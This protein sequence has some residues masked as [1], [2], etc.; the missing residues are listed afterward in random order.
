MKAYSFITS[1]MGK[2]I[3]TLCCL[4]LIW[5]N[6]HTQSSGDQLFASDKPLE[7]G[8]HIA[9]RDVADTKKD[10]VYIRRK[11]NFTMEDGQR[12]SIDVS[13]KSRGNF[14]L[15]E[16]HFPPLWLKFEK[17][18]A[19]GTVFQGN[20]KLKLV[21]PCRSDAIGNQLIV[22][23][24]LCYKIYEQIS[25]FVFRTRLVNVDFTE[26]RGKKEKHFQLKGILIE[27]VEKL[28]DRLGAKT[29]EEAKVHS[30]A[31]EDTNALRFAFFQ[32]MIANTDLSRTYQHNT[33][34]IQAKDG[35]YY[36]LPYDFDMSGLVDAPYAVVSKVGE[37]DLGIDDVKQR[38][39]RGWCRPTEITSFVR[40]EFITKKELLLSR[41]NLVKDELSEKEMTSIHDYLEDFFEI[42]ESDGLFDRYVVSACRSAK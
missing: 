21:L 34:L 38:L 5:I 26:I 10:S 18:V 24:Y 15:Q 25:G 39:Y 7:I 36:S 12:D 31:L 28:A 41:I 13:L 40:R 19:K 20:K 30:L 17:K 11:L 4:C 42:M 16:C 29:R 33:K 37:N 22:K 1:F 8:L 27:D 6:G 3:H 23:E 2:I 32:L 9:I 14:R 35:R